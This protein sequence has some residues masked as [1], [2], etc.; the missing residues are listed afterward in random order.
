MRREILQRRRPS[1]P[2]RAG[3]EIVR[4]HRRRH[5]RVG[6]ADPEPAAALRPA[7]DAT[8]AAGKRVHRLARLVETA[9]EKLILHIGR[10]RPARVLART[11]RSAPPPSS[12][13]RGGRATYSS[14]ACSLPQPAARDLVHRVALA[15]PVDD[16]GAEM[17]LQVLA[18]PRQ[19]VHDR[20]A[21]LAQQLA[22]PTPESC[23]NC[24]E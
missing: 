11:A 17:V 19:F 3:R 6:R 24:G 1:C 14:P 12:A 9:G 22:G 23:S 7:R 16:A 10:V 20:D 5:A 15:R 13:R 21:V 4:L 8:R 18:D 2:C